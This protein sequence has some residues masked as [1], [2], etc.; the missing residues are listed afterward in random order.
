MDEPRSDNSQ[1]KPVANEKCMTKLQYLRSTVNVP[2]VP[3]KIVNFCWHGAYAS[4]IPYITVYMKALGL[5]VRETAI[6]Y[7]IL[8]IA[9]VI[10]PILGGVIADRTGRYKAVYLTALLMCAAFTM[11]FH[12]IPIISPHCSRG[13]VTVSCK[14]SHYVVTFQKSCPNAENITANLDIG[15]CQLFCSEK[16]QKEHDPIY[17]FAQCRNDTCSHNTKSKFRLTAHY[18]TEEDGCQL[19]VTSVEDPNFNEMN[20]TCDGEYWENAIPSCNI[21]CVVSKVD[22]VTIA[23]NS[24]EQ[25]RYLTIVLCFAMNVALQFFTALCFSMLD[26]TIVVMVSKH[27][28]HFGR[29]RL[30]ACVGQ[31]TFSPLTGYLIDVFSERWGYADYSVAFYVFNIL[32]VAEAIA[33]YTLDLSAPPVPKNFFKNLRQLVSSPKINL[34]FATVFFLGVFWGFLEAFLFW[35]LLDLGSPNYLLGLTLTIGALASIPFLYCS[36]WFI[37]TLGHSNLLII[38]LLFYF[39][40]YIGYSVMVSPWWSIVYEAMEFATYHFMWVTVATYSGILAPEGMLATVEGFAGALHFGLARG[41]GSFVGGFMIDG[42]G[43]RLAF[44]ITGGFAAFIA[45]AYAAGNYW[46]TRKEQ[47]TR[48]GEINGSAKVPMV[49]IKTVNNKEDV[50]NTANHISTK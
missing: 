1:Q 4:L 16:V 24:S 36:E 42:L 32:I 45:I 31:A 10:A 11:S 46:F 12:F 17:P 38:A 13:L 19:N 20:S 50:G 21:R 29:Q 34:F 30:W 22:N 8:P 48:N 6:I 35:Y 39:I 26:A 27:G 23:C 5:T 18:I 14:S 41:F 7:A 9:E 40:R 15:E 25:I 37:K 44:R 2:L 28:S 49:A 47:S 3:L 43:T 33:V